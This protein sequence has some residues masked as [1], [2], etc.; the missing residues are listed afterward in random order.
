MIIRNKNGK[1]TVSYRDYVIAD[2]ITNFKE[3][4]ALLARTKIAFTP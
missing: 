3:A 2:D 4:R 1:Y